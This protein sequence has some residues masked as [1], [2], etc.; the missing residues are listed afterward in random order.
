MRLFV[1]LPPPEPVLAHLRAQPAPPGLRPARAG[2]EH[3]T[4]GFLGEVG[5]PAPLVARLDEPLPR[6]AA[7]RL[8]LSGAG[9]FGRGAVWLGVAGDLGA[10][11]ALRRAVEQAVL[12]AGLP[13]LPGTGHPG[14]W[15]PHVT[16]GR[17]S[18]PEQLEAYDGQEAAWP[19]VALVRSTLL[20]Q[21]AQHEVLHRW[22]L[23]TAATP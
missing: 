1:S 22:A 12:E 20:P 8:R 7:P 2:Q 16:I 3:V 4:L 19:E 6:L 9:R 5:D 21:G 17:G 13:P 10:L 18:V 11:R 15:R 23:Q 14:A